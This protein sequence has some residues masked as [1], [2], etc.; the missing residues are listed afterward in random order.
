MPIM[1]D[2]PDG[3]TQYDPQ[4]ELLAKAVKYGGYQL[5]EFDPDECETCH[6]I[7]Q[8]YFR[9]PTDAGA[10]I[11]GECVIDEHRTSEVALDKLV[12]EMV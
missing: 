4:S 1:N 3:Q 9:G 11:C 12:E 7:K 10:Y 2:S 6:K 8:L 5:C